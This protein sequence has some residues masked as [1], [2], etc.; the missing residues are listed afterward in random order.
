MVRPLVFA[1]MEE[2]R[3]AIVRSYRPAHAYDHARAVKARRVRLVGAPLHP[4][5]VGY[6]SER[7]GTRDQVF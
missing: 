4:D 2:P 7:D 1:R 6:A 3:V 5:Q